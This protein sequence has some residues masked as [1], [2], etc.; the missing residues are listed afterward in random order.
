MLKIEPPLYVFYSSDITPVFKLADPAMTIT[1][2][3]IDTA[4]SVQGQSLVLLIDV[5]FT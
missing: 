5:D 4:N 2:L 1:K 3:A